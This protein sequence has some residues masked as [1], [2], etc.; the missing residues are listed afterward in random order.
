MKERGFTKFLILA[1]F[2]V[3]AV[4]FSVTPSE[5]KKGKKDH[6]HGNH[7]SVEDAERIVISVSGYVLKSKSGGTIKVDYGS[8]REIDLLNGGN[9]AD[10]IFDGPLAE[11]KYRSLRLNVDAEKNVIDSYIEIDG[12]KHSLWIPGAKRSGLKIVKRFRVSESG[13]PDLSFR[14]N[15]KKSVHK[16]KGDN[17]I[18]KPT[19]KLTKRYRDGHVA[20]DSDDEDVPVVTTGSI[21][22]TIPM[23][24]MQPRGVSCDT[25][26]AIYLFEGYSIV[27]DDIDGNDPNP[28]AL[29][30]VAYDTALLSYAYNMTSVE[31]GDYTVT[32]T[33]QAQRDD[34]STDDLLRFS[35]GGNVTVSPGIASEVNF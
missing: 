25:I 15:A 12:V 17:Y 24:V 16:A 32:F 29:G 9:L 31:E 1:L 30:N 27:P 33:C 13:I 5:A 35:V 7:F 28:V 3:A 18:L 21:Y 8:P 14:F 2:I 26:T 19:I 11:G 6:K 10:E 34:A 22:G 23:S 4:I 20:V